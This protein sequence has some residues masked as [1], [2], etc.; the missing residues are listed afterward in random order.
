MPNIYFDCCALNRPLDDQRHPQVAAEAA[1]V[2]QILL[3]VRW[4]R[5]RWLG[6]PIL[7][8]EIEACADEERKAILLSM[9]DELCLEQTIRIDRTDGMLG[10]LQA[11]H[12][13]LPDAVHV[14]SA[15]MIGADIFITCDQQLLKKC[16]K[17]QPLTKLSVLSPLQA[18]AEL[19]L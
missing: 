10:A 4:K 9:L 3:L 19:S 5:I 18:V 12:L 6:A 7:R 1:A 13:S 15:S 11:L 8:V 16:G 14:V 2:R 17:I